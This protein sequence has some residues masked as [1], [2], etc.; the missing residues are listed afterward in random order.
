[1]R[2]R[3]PLRMMPPRNLVVLDEAEDEERAED[4]VETLIDDPPSENSIAT[5]ELDVAVKLPRMEVVPMELVMLVTRLVKP[6][7][8]PLKRLSPTSLR[9]PKKRLPPR[10]P[11]SPKTSVSLSINTS[12]NN[13]RFNLPVLSS[14]ANL[15]ELLIP[16]LSPTF[17]LLPRKTK[18]YLPRLPSLKRRKLNEL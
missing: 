17:P 10:P 13:L 6:P 16:L 8:S 4:E 7:E 1:M 12:N 2:L 5:Q 11:R 3:L 9:L 15:P 14:P 18:K